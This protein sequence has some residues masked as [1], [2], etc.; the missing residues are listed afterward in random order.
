MLEF[1]KEGTEKMSSVSDVLLKREYYLK[2]TLSHCAS[3]LEIPSMLEIVHTISCSAQN[4][5]ETF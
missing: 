3:F 4:A 5:K 2:F 1:F